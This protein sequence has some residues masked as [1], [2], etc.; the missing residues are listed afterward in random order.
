MLARLILFLEH[1]F[2]NNIQLT[3]LNLLDIGGGPREPTK[4][5][6]STS[7]MLSPTNKCTSLGGVH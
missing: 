4:G 5:L 1:A 7:A 6:L 3:T 2:S